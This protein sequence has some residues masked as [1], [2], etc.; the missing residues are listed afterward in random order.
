MI[1]CA[2]VFIHVCVCVNSCHFFSPHRIWLFGTTGTKM[3]LLIYLFSVH[4]GSFFPLLHLH[5]FFFY[6]HSIVNVFASL[7]LSYWRNKIEKKP[8]CVCQWWSQRICYF[9]CRYFSIL[10][11]NAKAFVI[12]FDLCLMLFFMYALRI[13]NG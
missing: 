11:P 2:V 6:F 10:I 1:W 5:I 9:D 8:Q 3:V 7:L 12:C 4:I 13:N